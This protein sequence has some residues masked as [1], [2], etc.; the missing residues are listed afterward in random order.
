MKAVEKAEAGDA[1]ESVGHPR[2][3]DDSD[4]LGEPQPGDPDVDRAHVEPPGIGA[5]EKNLA[6]GRLGSAEDVA[7]AVAFLVSDQ[8]GWITGQTLMV[9]GGY[10]L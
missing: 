8:A 10:A 2:D 4:R 7:G 5:A 1:I 6:L 3:A 9:D